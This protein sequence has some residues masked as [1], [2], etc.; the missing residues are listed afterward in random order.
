M[1]RHTLSILNILS[2]RCPVSTVKFLG[3]TIDENLTWLPHLENL[4]K[5][6]TC[7]Q[8]VLYRTKDS[9]PKSLYKTLSHSLF[10]SHL[11]YGISIWGAQS[12]TV[13]YELFTLF[14]CS[15]VMSV[16]YPV[17]ACAC[18]AVLCLYMCM[19]YCILH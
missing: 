1:Q 14:S 3:V 15:V 12:H 6:L 9:V 17:A 4:R 13:L 18:C 19:I 5:K 8:G 2:N 11:I 10:E 16:I 7:S